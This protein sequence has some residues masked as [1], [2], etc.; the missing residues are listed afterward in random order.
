MDNRALGPRVQV[1]PERLVNVAAG[2]GRGRPG[3][4]APGGCRP[5]RACRYDTRPTPTT[6]VATALPDLVK[7]GLPKAAWIHDDRLV[8]WGG[9][10]QQP[11]PGGP[12]DPPGSPLAGNRR[13]YRG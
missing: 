7:A 8:L 4:G 9:P 5:G 13:S 10:G 6:V 11:A 3:S 12:Q 2:A 1:R